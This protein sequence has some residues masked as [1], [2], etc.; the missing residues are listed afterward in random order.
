MLRFLASAMN[1]CRKIS[2]TH[3]WEISCS[4]AM[5]CKGDKMKVAFFALTLKLPEI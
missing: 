5:D 1:S 4:G 3:A 2:G